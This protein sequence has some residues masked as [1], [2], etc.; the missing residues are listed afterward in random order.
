MDLL[1]ANNR[2]HDTRDINWSGDL[3]TDGTIH[4]GGG[5][6]G[7]DYDPSTRQKVRVASFLRMHNNGYV[8]LGLFVSDSI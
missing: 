8:S 7:S 5:H 6:S 2:D 4:L 1:L 3:N